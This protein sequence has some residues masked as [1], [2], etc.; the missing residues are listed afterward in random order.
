MTHDCALGDVLLQ[1]LRDLADEVDADELAYLAATS[2]VE[3]PV[4]DRF[5]WR[6]HRRLEPHG[7]T[8]AREWKRA[9]LAVLDGATVVAVLEA[10][11]LYA[12][13]LLREAQRTRDG[14][15]IA[16][17]MA[18]AALLAPSAQRFALVLVTHVTG[19]VQPD[20]RANVVKYAG[21]I[22][23]ALLRHGGAAVRQGALTALGEDLVALGTVD[24]VPFKH[25]LAFGL[26]VGVDAWLVNATP[27]EPLGPLP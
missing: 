26:E 15:L 8:V 10:K 19:V 4:R 3:L 11:A 14:T 2:K 18:K 24:H 25:G 23:A 12:F 7:L 21:G 6:L 5:A 1:E 9:D 17:D 27:D 22:S 20:L 16:G 13:D